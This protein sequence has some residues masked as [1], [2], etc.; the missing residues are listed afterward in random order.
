MDCTMNTADRP[1]LRAI[2]GW[3]AAPLARLRSRAAAAKAGQQAALEFMM[4][5]SLTDADLAR[6][7]ATRAVLDAELALRAR[8]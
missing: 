3:L 6:L 2:A 5:A 8:D 7:G 4:L 1:G